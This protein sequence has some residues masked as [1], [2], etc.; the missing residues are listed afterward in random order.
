MS[1]LACVGI[2]ASRISPGGKKMNKRKSF[3]ILSLVLIIIWYIVATFNYKI[4]ETAQ[5]NKFTISSSVNFWIAFEYI[6]S[7][8]I[9]RDSGII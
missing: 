1:N 9:I 5:E 7:A 6:A 8:P 2:Y 3:F 4:A